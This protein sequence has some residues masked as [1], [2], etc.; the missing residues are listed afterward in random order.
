M[1]VSQ[2]S[3]EISS[4]KIKGKT[5]LP[6]GAQT[7]NDWPMTLCGDPQKRVRMAAPGE[8]PTCKVCLRKG[9]LL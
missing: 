4:P 8:A 2:E 1:K 6:G 7:S 3:R 9:G 5:H